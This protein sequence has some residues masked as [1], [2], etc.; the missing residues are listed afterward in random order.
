MQTINIICVGKL[1]EQYLKDAQ[2]EYAKRLTAFCKLNIIELDESMKGPEE[3][4]KAILNKIEK[5][6][7]VY[8]MC[9]E[10]KQM[11]SE[12]LAEEISRKATEGKSNLTFIIGGSLGLSDD[13]KNRADIRLSMSEMTFPHHLARIMLEEQIYRAYQINSNGKYHK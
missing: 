10:G 11:S 4:G 3:E 9:I 5:D 7:F 1:K 6:A 8:A 13:V 2:K 12:K